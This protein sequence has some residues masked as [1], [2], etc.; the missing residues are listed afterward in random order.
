[1]KALLI[2][3]EAK[4]RAYRRALLGSGTNA[5]GTKLT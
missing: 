2:S 4:P 1:M 3:A 5:A